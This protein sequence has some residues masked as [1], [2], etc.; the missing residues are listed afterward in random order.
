MAVYAFKMTIPGSKENRPPTVPAGQINSTVQEKLPRAVRTLATLPGRI[1]E[2]L[3]AA[4]LDHLVELEASFFPDRLRP[5]FEA[6]RGAIVPAN[7]SVAQG[8]EAMT[9]E[10]ACEIAQK[11][12][13]LEDDLR[14]LLDDLE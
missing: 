14:S 4:C 12:V 11:I 2:R 6:I 3:A 1:K 7:K 10:V 8:V 13:R 5:Q 9:E